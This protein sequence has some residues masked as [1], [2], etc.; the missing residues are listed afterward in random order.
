[1]ELIDNLSL[2]LSSRF[3]I[4]VIKFFTWYKFRVANELC[5]NFEV[6]H[7][8]FELTLEYRMEIIS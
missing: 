7:R 3:R 6:R 1:M 5:F 4:I 2:S 8:Q